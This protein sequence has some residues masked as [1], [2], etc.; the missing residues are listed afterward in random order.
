MFGFCYYNISPD[1]HLARCHRCCC[2]MRHVMGMSNMDCRHRHRTD[3]DI[4][5]P[6]KSGI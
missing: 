4:A 2:R 3:G 5:V 1:K 6:I